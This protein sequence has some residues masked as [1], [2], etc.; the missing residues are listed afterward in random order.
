VKGITGSEWRWQERPAAR[1]HNE[2]AG[3]AAPA[4]DWLNPKNERNRNA[5]GGGLP[6]FERSAEFPLACGRERWL[7]ELREQQE[8]FHGCGEEI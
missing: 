1:R 2:L 3:Q 5:C 6:A 7:D 8:F 4:A